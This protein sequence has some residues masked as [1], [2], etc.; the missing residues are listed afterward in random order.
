MSYLPSS[1]LVT[2]TL[3]VSEMAQNQIWFPD[4]PSGLL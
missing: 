4:S 1:G 3:R 2:L